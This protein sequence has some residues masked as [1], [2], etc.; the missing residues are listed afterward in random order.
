MLRSPGKSHPHGDP[1][2]EGSPLLQ[3]GC[4]HGGKHRTAELA[5][6]TDG[7]DL[8]SRYAHPWHI[9]ATQGQQRDAGIIPH[10]MHHPASQWE[11]VPRHRPKHLSAS[12]FPVPSSVQAGG[13]LQSV[14]GR[15]SWIREAVKGPMLLWRKHL[16]QTRQSCKTLSRT[17]REQGSKACARKPTSVGK[18]FYK[19]VI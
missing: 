8:T 14:V 16:S 11:G 5:H 10:P 6:S 19:A 4:T 17:E 7:A 18:M 13:H 1:S 3:Q 2:P 15:I 9:P 12:R